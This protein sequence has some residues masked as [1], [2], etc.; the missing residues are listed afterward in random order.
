MPFFSAWVTPPNKSRQKL[1]SVAVRN[2][3]SFGMTTTL[4]YILHAFIMSHLPKISSSL[5]EITS[6]I[7]GSVCI[8][9]TKIATQRSI[10]FETNTIEQ[11]E[12]NSLLFP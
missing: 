10:I 4:Y 5:Q 8:F 11:V 9:E 6:S 1:C 2:F 12:K 3:L 7:R